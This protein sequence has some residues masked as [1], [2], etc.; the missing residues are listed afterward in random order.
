MEN[1]AEENFI[2]NK[3][4][5]VIVMPGGDGTG[6]M[7]YGPAT[8]GRRGGCVPSGGFGRGIGRGFNRMMPWNWFSSQK[9][10]LSYLE[11]L[12]GNISDQIKNLKSQMNKD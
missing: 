9:D 12:Q 10:E 4:K 11:Q 1:A 6:P 8:G 5:E 3:R 7:G 2:K